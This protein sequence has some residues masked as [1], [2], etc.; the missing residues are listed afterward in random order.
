MSKKRQLLASWLLTFCGCSI[1]WTAISFSLFIGYSRVGP[2]KLKIESLN[3][4]SVRI[5][6][7]SE[8]EQVV[9]VHYTI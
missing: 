9:I 4:I 8:M 6:A 1:L 3:F 5:L 7:H 2:K